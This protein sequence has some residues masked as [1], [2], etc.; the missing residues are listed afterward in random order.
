VAIKNMLEALVGVVEKVIIEVSEEDG[1]GAKGKG[2]EG[3]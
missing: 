3:G 1:Q 2:I